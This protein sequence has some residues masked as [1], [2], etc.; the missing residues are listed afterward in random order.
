MTIFCAPSSRIVAGGDILGCKCMIFP[1]I[2]VSG[3][4]K[5]DEN[6]NVTMGV[7]SYQLVWQFRVVTLTR[8]CNHYMFLSSALCVHQ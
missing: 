3:N 4:S 1:V 8:I 7:N 2:V 6:V 5:G